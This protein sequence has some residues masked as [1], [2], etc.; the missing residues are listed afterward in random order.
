MTTH[1]RAYLSIGTNLG[2]RLPNLASAVRA[3]TDARGIE[4]VDV[5]PVYETAPLGPEGVVV[6]TEPAYLNCAVLIETRLSVQALRAETQRIEHA[7]GR[8]EHGRWESR[9]IDIDIVLFGDARIATAQLTVPHASMFERAFVLRPLVDLDADLWVDGVGKLANLLPDLVWQRCDLYAAA[10]TLR[11]I[12]TS[13]AADLIAHGVA[14][15]GRGRLGAALADA[16][17]TAGVI[18]TG[19]LGRGATADAASVVLLCVPDREIATAAAAVAPG[20]LVGHCSGVATLEPLAPHEAFSMHPL[21]TV[22][23]TSAPQFRGAGCAVSGSTPRAHAVADSLGRTLGMCPV[24]IADS[25]RALYHAAATVASNYLVTLECVA[26]RLARRVGVS[27]EMLA[28]L[29]RASLENWIAHGS[30]AL[31]GPIARGDVETVERQRVAIDTREPELLA[32]W[33]ALARQTALLVAG[34]RLP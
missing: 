29:A 4:I 33:D 16:L 12:G 24:E 25:D 2:D 7:M 31:T 26:E 13:N 1:T 21:M 32:L 3:L 19:P 30:E 11:A 10:D 8:G 22:V 15:V 23:R 28:P 17:R 9:V 6:D 5:S 27:R 18:V 34:R 14:I 20:R